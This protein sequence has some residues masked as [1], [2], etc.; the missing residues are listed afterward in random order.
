MSIRDGFLRHTRPN[1]L[2]WVSLFFSNGRRLISEHLV[3]V[4]K[5]SAVGTDNAVPSRLMRQNG[6]AEEALRPLKTRRQIDDAAAK[7]QGFQ[8]LTGEV[9]GAQLRASPLD[10]RY[11][12]VVVRQLG[13][14]SVL[15]GQEPVV[16]VGNDFLE[17]RGRQLHVAL[18]TLQDRL[19]H[20][21]QSEIGMPLKQRPRE[22]GRAN[23]SQKIL[24]R[25]Y[26]RLPVGTWQ[27][28]R[29]L[30]AA[31]KFLIVIGSSG[32]GSASRRCDGRGLD[33]F[34]NPQTITRVSIITFLLL[35]SCPPP[36]FLGLDGISCVLSSL[37]VRINLNCCPGVS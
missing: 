10:E 4:G 14:M 33:A 6:P 9:I 15:D 7:A 34:S 25:F 16:E 30:K 11:R 8:L 1:T 20:I 22:A 27:G 3:Q 32:P 35:T 21:H 2:Q 18:G 37:P 24:Y 36:Q 19:C 5:Q 23:F 26:E 29:K 28:Y 12:E 13:A 31:L 17:G